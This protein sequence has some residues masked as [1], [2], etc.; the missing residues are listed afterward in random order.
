MIA[1]MSEGEEATSEILVPAPAAETWDAITDPERLSEWLGDGAEL[2]LQPGGELEIE[3]D[4]ERR[5][6]FIEEVEPER[7]LVFWWRREAD[8]DSSRVEIELEP[9]RE[10]TRVRVIESRPLRL[11]DLPAIEIESGFDVGGSAPQMSAG[12]LALVG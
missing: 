10:G 8:E 12:P 2:D 9:E 4:D 6:G 11:L 5:T 3:V 1:S 7:R